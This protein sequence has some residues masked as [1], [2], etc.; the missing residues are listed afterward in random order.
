MSDDSSNDP[1]SQSINFSELLQKAQGITSKMS[2]AQAELS[3]IEVTGEAG[4]GIVR[5]TANG[6]ME[7]LSTEIDPVAVDPRDVPMLQDLITAATNAALRRARERAAEHMSSL[8]G[9]L[10][11]G[12]FFS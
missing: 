5:V 6:K 11:L 2:D 4:G 7:V 1:G 12:S 9:G 3:S 10:D 8:T